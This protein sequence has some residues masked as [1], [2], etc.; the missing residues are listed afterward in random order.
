MI[1]DGI[2]ATRQFLQKVYHVSFCSDIHSVTI[3]DEQPGRGGT[4]VTELRLELALVKAAIR[5]TL[6]FDHL[7]ETVNAVYS[8]D[9]ESAYAVVENLSRQARCGRGRALEAFEHYKL[10]SFDGLTDCE[11]RTGEERVIA[12]WMEFSISVLTEEFV[13]RGWI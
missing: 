5:K 7:I 4:T 2:H 12:R 1:S 9:P 11:P 13:A 6:G 10:M 8:D 3:S